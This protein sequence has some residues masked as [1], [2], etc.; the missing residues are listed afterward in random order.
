MVSVRLYRLSRWRWEGKTASGDGTVQAMLDGKPNTC[1]LSLRWELNFIIMQMYYYAN[2]PHFTLA[3]VSSS[4]VVRASVLDHGGSWVRIP[5][6]FFRV[7]SGFNCNTFH[8]I[9]VKTFSLIRKLYGKKLHC[10]V[11][12]HVV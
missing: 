7:P 4:S 1:N 5:S 11:I 12:Q 2:Y 10:I 6:G 9:C 3:Q 8:L